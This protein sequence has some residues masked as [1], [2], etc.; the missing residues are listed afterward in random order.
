ML[1]SLFSRFEHII[2]LDTETTGIDPKA[3]E[4]IELGGIR[5]TYN[6]GETDRELGLLVRLSEGRRLP[7]LITDLTGIT[8]G[9]LEKRGVSK[10]SAGMELRDLLNCQKP[11]LVAYNAQFD[12][13]FLYFFLRR[14]GLESALSGIGML[15]ALTIY[16]DRRPY[17]H[18][19]ADAVAAYSLTVQNTHRAI[20]DAKATLELLCAMEKESDDLAEYINLFGYNPRY[21]VSGSKISS[22]RY[23]P[24]EYNAVKKLYQV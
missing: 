14:L 16:K 13:N 22:V 12:L 2:I 21:G 9:Q 3:D 18:K 20:D 5:L 6:R 1:D 23:L 8:A 24:Q 19:L 17:P 11:L 15:D 7:P 4:I 10:E